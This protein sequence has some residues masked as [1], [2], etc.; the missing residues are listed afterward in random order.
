MSEEYYIFTANR[1]KHN[2]NVHKYYQENREQILA[3]LKEKRDLVKVQ[4]AE[5]TYVPVEKLTRRRSNEVSDIVEFKVNKKAFAAR[6]KVYY[7]KNSEEIKRKKREKYQLDKESK[8]A[9]YQANRKEIL[10]KAR[11]RYQNKK[12]IVSTGDLLL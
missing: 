5:G 8:D 10:E 6:A 3:K 9:Y 4:K 2:A 12:L 7:E 11:I 1:E